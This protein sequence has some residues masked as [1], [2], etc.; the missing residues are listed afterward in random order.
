MLNTSNSNGSFIGSIK[1]AILKPKSIEKYPPNS[2]PQ[3]IADIPPIPTSSASFFMPVS[4]RLD[5]PIKN[6]AIA[7]TTPYAASPI[8]MP[9]NKK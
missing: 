3:I 5:V 7:S 1:I 2:M 8:I 6:P 9:K 4:N